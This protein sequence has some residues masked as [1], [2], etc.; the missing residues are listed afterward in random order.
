MSLKNS[1]GPVGSSLATA[2]PEEAATASAHALPASQMPPE[3]SLLAVQLAPAASL[4]G[5]L[6]PVG[7]VGPLAPLGP[8]A[9]DALLL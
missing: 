7:P 3:Q 1:T 5:T 9:W 2:Q 4:V 8:V 6:G